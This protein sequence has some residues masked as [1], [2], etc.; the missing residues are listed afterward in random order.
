[1]STFA[2]F[3]SVNIA[4]VVFHRIVI[5]TYNFRPC[6]QWEDNSMQL[7][8]SRVE[9]SSTQKSIQIP[10]WLP[11]IC[12]EVNAKSNWSF[13][14]QMKYFV[15]IE[16]TSARKYLHS[17]CYERIGVRN[18]SNES[19]LTHVRRLFFIGFY[20]ELFA[21][22]LSAN[23][24][25]FDYRRFKSVEWCAHWCANLRRRFRISCHKRLTVRTI[26]IA[27]RKW[28][29]FWLNEWIMKSNYWIKDKRTSEVYLSEQANTHS[30]WRVQ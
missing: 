15:K 30:H 13:S 24:N 6:N 29:C 18:A 28:N 22:I 21:I 27:A 12:F 23:L 7:F 4:C 14:S 3:V 25:H 9:P 8:I 20:R 19:T 10:K 11:L 17:S 2:I 26:T 1:M 16:S 5:S